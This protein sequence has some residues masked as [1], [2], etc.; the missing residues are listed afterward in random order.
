MVMG[1]GIEHGETVIEHGGRADC[2]RADYR[3]LDRP[4]AGAGG[5]TGHGG[6]PCRTGGNISR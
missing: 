6:R 2:E 5:L 1:H 3:L 4:A